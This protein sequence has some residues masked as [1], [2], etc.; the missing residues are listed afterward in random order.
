MRSQAASDV[1]AP[2]RR[3]AQGQRAQPPSPVH[4][5]GK[6][7]DDLI[8]L[9]QPPGRG[10][11]LQ[12]GRQGR[13]SAPRVGAEACPVGDLGL[14]DA[15]QPP[16]QLRQLAGGG[17]TE[18]LAVR[19]DVR[20]FRGDTSVAHCWVPPRRCTHSPDLLRKFIRNAVR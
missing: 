17:V 5:R 4:V 19:A 3:Q 6:R 13:R 14:A 11:F 20:D 2:V 12:G 8:K 9:F 10:A 18:Q 7:A 16:A 15:W 1:G